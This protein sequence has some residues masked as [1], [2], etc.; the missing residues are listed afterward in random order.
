MPWT[1]QGIWHC[2]YIDITKAKLHHVPCPIFLCKPPVAIKIV[3][4]WLPVRPISPMSCC[5]FSTGISRV[6]LFPS[7]LAIEQGNL[8]IPESINYAA[9]NSSV[10]ASLSITNSQHCGNDQLLP[11][12][13]LCVMAV[14][15]VPLIAV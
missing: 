12:L 3:C 8:A 11:Q 13:L 10:Q 4:I 6:D 15:R 1:E 9:D 14:L 7:R 2:G 5:C